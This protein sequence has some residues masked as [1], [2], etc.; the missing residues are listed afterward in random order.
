MLVLAA[1]DDKWCFEV[2]RRLEECHKARAAKDAEELEAK[3][4]A[5]EK[6]RMLQK[7]SESFTREKEAE[8]DKKLRGSPRGYMSARK[9]AGPA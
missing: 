4:L 1:P 6:R 5:E 3:K 7:R 2:T 9:P 8:D